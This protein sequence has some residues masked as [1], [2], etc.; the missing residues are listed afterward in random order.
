MTDAYRPPQRCSARRLTSLVFAALLVHGCATPPVSVP[1]AERTAGQVE[2]FLATGD[3]RGAADL[4]L[5]AADRAASPRREALQLEAAE[6]LLRGQLFDAAESLLDRL[7]QAGDADYQTRL[8]IARARLLIGRGQPE[9]ALQNLVAL[10]DTVPVA[11]LPSFHQVRAEAYAAAGN[12]LESAR[13]RVWLD[14]LLDAAARPANQQAIWQA[15]AQLP[16]ALLAGLRTAPPP[17]VFSGWLELVETTRGKR[18]DPAQLDLALAIWQERYPRHPASRAFILGLRERLETYTQQVAAPTQIGVLLPLS[19]PLAEAGMAVRDGLLAA[20]YQA[21]TGPA[22]QLRFYDTG[23]GAV[24]ARYQEAISAGA[25]QII[26]PLT[27]EAVAVLA[28]SGPLSVP[29]LALNLLPEGSPA[30][31]QF[32]QFGLAPEDEAIQVATRA[33]EDGH[34]RAL[35]LIPEGVWGERVLHAF[36]Q[37]WQTLGGSLLDVQRYGTDQREYSNRVRE[38]L[39]IDASQRRHQALSRLLGR[40]PEFEPRRRQDADFIFL[41]GQAQQAR[42]L[43]PLLRFHHAGQLPVYATSQVYEG[44]ANA[45]LDQDLDGVRFCDMP[46]ILSSEHP[47]RALRSEIE[48]LWPARAARHIRLYALGIDALQ[49]TPYLRGLSEGLFARHPGVTGDIYLDRDRRVHRDLQWAQFHRGVPIDLPANPPR[50]VQPTASDDLE[51]QDFTDEYPAPDHTPAA[52]GRA[53]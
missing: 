10:S 37:H 48:R 5:A 6:V 2:Q 47:G 40:Q 52:P 34:R 3:H 18:D 29:V 12:L 21:P 44:T 11:L 25:Q 4:L 33:W 27:K 43:R 9:A 14:G 49:I 30:P 24:L 20:H 8:A 26:G 17:D 23:D 51:P 22:G 32:Y 19:G 45:A 7:P 13:E 16:N 38:L 42:L 36:A 41:I 28:A 39:N 1:P 50:T 31:A 15:L 53:R 46:W 35:A